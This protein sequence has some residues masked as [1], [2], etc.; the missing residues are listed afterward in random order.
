M[1]NDKSVTEKETG[2]G[3]SLSYDKFYDVQ[4]VNIAEWQTKPYS[5]IY[6]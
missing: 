4:D 2:F 1:S 6:T 3:S 5:T